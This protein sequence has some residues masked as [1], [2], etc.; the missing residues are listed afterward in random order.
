M[1]SKVILNRQIKKVKEIKLLQLNFNDAFF[2]D[3]YVG[4]HKLYKNL[5]QNEN[6][7]K[8][9]FKLVRVRKQNFLLRTKQ[10]T[11]FYGPLFVLWRNQIASLTALSPYLHEQLY[12]VCLK[13][14]FLKIQLNDHKISRPISITHFVIMTFI[15]RNIKNN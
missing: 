1:L 2:G 12:T 5:T 10:N 9:F 6:I 3:Q 4:M 7:T 8:C 15:M 14:S 13:N 11:I